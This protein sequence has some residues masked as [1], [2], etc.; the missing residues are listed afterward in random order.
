[1]EAHKIYTQTFR[2]VSKAYA[3]AQTY[4]KA[5]EVYL[6]VSFF[7][8]GETAMG[9]EFESSET[10]Q[11]LLVTRIESDVCHAILEAKGASATFP[12]NGI[13][14]HERDFSNATFPARRVAA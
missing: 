12:V 11:T 9:V 6:P 10:D 7:L 2:G 3:S 5:W 13:S 8:V 4:S 14:F 1:M